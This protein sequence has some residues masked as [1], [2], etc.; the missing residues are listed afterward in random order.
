MLVD[1]IGVPMVTPFDTEG[2]VDHDRLRNLVT[3]LEARDADFL[4][5]CGST[6]EAELLTQDERAAVVETVVEAASV[7]V[8]AGTGHPGRRETL[9][10]TRAAAAAGADAAMV[11]TPFY[12]NHDQETLATYY[13]EVADAADLPIYLYAVPVFTHTRLTPA[14]VA[15]LAEHP[16][17]VGVKDSSGDLGALSRMTD[18]VPDDFQILVGSADI[19]A[20]GLA[21]GANGGILAV[22]NLRPEASAAVTSGDEELDSGD[23][24]VRESAADLAALN[25]TVLE[26]GIPGLKWVMRQGGAPAGYPRSPHRP[27]DEAAQESLR[28]SLSLD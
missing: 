26:Y 15:D 19:L 12:Y 25:A 10:S 9:E 5:P 24:S 14:T 1:G 28:T 11:V 20:S 6:S 17:I 8:V 3:G 18:L 7:P 27:L 4:V 16:N 13:R 23:P 2:D 22:A 21:A